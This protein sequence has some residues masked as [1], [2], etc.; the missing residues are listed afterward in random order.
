MMKPISLAL[1]PAALFSISALA[2][3]AA[4]FTPTPANQTLQATGQGGPQKAGLRLSRKHAPTHANA[5]KCN[6]WAAIRLAIRRDA[7]VLRAN[8]P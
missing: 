2:Q 1:V 8:D 3:P 6:S 7:H 5:R 4:N